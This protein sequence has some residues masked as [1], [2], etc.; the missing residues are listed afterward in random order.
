MD[1]HPVVRAG[2]VTLLSKESTLQ[3]VGSAHS[4]DEALLLLDRFPVDLML[5]DLRMPKIS[6]IDLLHMLKS[7]SNSPA[8]VIL[9]SYEYEDEI[10]CA[11]QAGVSRLYIKECVA[12]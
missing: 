12:R 1:D 6:G 10:Y 9:S 11:A 8:V 7:R 2:L 5:L 3:V 4:A